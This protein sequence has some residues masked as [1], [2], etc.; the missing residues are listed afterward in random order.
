MADELENLVASYKRVASVW[1]VVRRHS[2]MKSSEY[3][4]TIF[5]HWKASIR[6]SAAVFSQKKAV[7]V[8]RRASFCSEYSDDVLN[9]DSSGNIDRVLFHLF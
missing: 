5:R 4:A 9:R 1:R 6:L 2:H 8:F 7:S 3:L